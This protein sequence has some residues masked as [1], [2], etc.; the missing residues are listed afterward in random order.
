MKDTLKAILDTIRLPAELTQFEDRYLARVNKIAT[1]F[2]VLH[3]PVFVLVAYLNDTGPGMAVLLTAAALIGPVVALKTFEN[4]RNVSLMHGFTS[5][6]MG[7]LLV[8]FGQG[9]VQIEMHFYFFAL[10]AMLAIFA[11]PMVILLAAGTVAV[12]HLALWYFLPESVFNYDA[13]L[14]VVLVHA[15]FVVL[16]SVATCYIARSFFDNVIGLERIVQARTKEVDEKNKQMRLVMDNVEQ[17]LLT[18]GSDGVVAQERSAVVD[19]WLGECRSGET[20]VDSLA[21][22]DERTADAFEAAFD[23]LGMGILPVECSI[24][25][26]PSEMAFD[27]RHFGLE[28]KPILR[29]EELVQLLV[30]LTDRT[31]IVRQE[32]L[33]TEQRETMSLIERSR[34]DQVGFLEFFD[35]AKVLVGAISEDLCEDLPLLKR[36]IHTLKGNSM[37]YEVHSIA[38]VCERMED[39]MSETQRRPDATLLDELARRWDRLKQSLR[40]VLDAEER[41]AVQIRPEQYRELIEK[42]LA[43]PTHRELANMLMSLRLEGT[44][45]RLERVGEQAQRIGNR[46]GK[47]DIR[48]EI[49]DGGLR[50]E[51][52]RWATF[53]QAFVH[54]VRNAIDH[55]LELEEERG[56]RGKAGGGTLT[57]STS[58]E[59][60]VFSIR[61][62]DDGRGID[63]DRVR[64]KAAAA[65]LPH[66]TSA[67]LEAALFHDGLT[68]RSEATLYSGRGV[69]LSAIRAACEERGGEVRVASRLGEGTAFEF[70]FPASEMAPSPT[71]YLAA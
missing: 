2:F 22:V 5:M 12:H 47:R 43:T 28:Y 17:G 14:W 40:V 71:E 46:L 64:T 13:P 53:W 65:G 41:D 57:L 69:G 1:W 54:V 25:Q 66:E 7:G 45:E 62:H 38:K 42:A 68:T 63:W 3:L 18:V 16:E 55:G 70:R 21:R 59:A 61:I 8:H 11:N 44:R 33:E 32:Q 15:A 23:Q 27:D 36:T 6:L 10:L 58:T 19:R 49:Q 31:A 56:A 24:D 29:G 50:L 37:L 26:F 34:E 67:D 39:A 51:P 35:E 52:A 30:V 4:P 9:P 48:V 60:G 20:F